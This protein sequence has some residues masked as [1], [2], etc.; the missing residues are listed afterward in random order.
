VNSPNG[1]TDRRVDDF[2]IDPHVLQLRLPEFSYNSA[3]LGHLAFG[4]WLVGAVRPSTIVELGVFTGA[5]FLAF[6]HAARQLNL[7]TRCYGVDTWKGDEHAGYY[8]ST[9][10]D[11]L[12]AH[13]RQHYPGS[14]ELVRS[15]FDEA[16]DLFDDGTVD[17]LHIDG[18]HLYDA[19]RHD[20]DSWRAKVSSRGVVLFHDIAV[21]I[22]DFGVHRLWS[23]LSQRFP[24]FAFLHSYGLGVLGVGEQFPPAVRYLFDAAADSD[25]AERIRRRFRQQSEVL[26]QALTPPLRLRIAYF[27]GIRV[28][29]VRSWRRA[30]RQYIRNLPW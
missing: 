21:T 2:D 28:Q 9:V 8:P 24:H 6:C 20:F 26:F 25:K 15:T 27:L 30:R 18:L 17:I 3:W 10:F 7:G 5:S 12:N 14:A 23:E 11:E 13:V 4:Q 29:S 19:V 16:V 1:L 22:G